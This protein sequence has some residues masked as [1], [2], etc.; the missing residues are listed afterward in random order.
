MGG[1]RMESFVPE[2]YRTPKTPEEKYVEYKANKTFDLL[3][4][5]HHR[6]WE[7]YHAML[8]GKRPWDITAT[9]DDDPVV[10]KAIK[11]KLLHFIDVKI[12]FED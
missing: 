4:E 6:A 10:D 11:D 5:V 12:G 1:N 2:K 7:I 9:F 3:W 8:N